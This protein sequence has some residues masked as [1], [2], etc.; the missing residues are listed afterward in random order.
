MKNKVK[1]VDCSFFI[2]EPEI[3]GSLDGSCNY[4]NK[5]KYIVSNKKRVCVA[6]ESKIAREL[7]GNL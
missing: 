1:C 5:T 3:I 6:F 2:P 4:R 7:D